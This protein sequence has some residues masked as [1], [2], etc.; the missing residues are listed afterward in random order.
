M[1]KTTSL[2]FC[3]TCLIAPLRSQDVEAVVKK[4]SVSIH[5][6][7]RGS[8]SLF[9]SAS[10][11]LTSLQPR[12]A[13]L[14]FERGDGRCERGRRARLV[15]GEAP[16]A[17]AG[18]VVRRLEGVSGIDKC[19][20]EFADALPEG[21]GIGIRVGGLIE[22]GEMKN[23]VFFGRPA[24]S[25]PNSSATIFVLEEKTSSARRVTVRYGVMSGP[26]IQVLEGLSPG[27]K[28]IVTDMSKWAS[29]PRVRIE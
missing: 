24:G 2:F 14:T 17:F 19:E 15:V 16:R 6:V 23:V 13:V 21:A 4:E 12:T 9:V 7:E 11:S 10:G 18:K 26:L 29:A 5:T 22:V 20:V 1:R 25:S 3:I 8:M 28:V 27:D